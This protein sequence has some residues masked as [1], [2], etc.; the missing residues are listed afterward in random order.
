MDE[1]LP[2]S[3]WSRCQ[4]IDRRLRYE[5]LAIDMDA[6]PMLV[7]GHQSG[8]EY[9]GYFH[10]SGYH[11]LIIGSAQ[12]GDFSGAVLRPGN[13]HAH[14]D[15]SDD[16][17]GLLSQRRLAP[18]HRIRCFAGWVKRL[19]RLRT[20]PKEEWHDTPRVFLQDLATVS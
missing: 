2:R 11:P 18:E 5:E 1:A 12:T 17:V 14:D 3:A 13:V 16:L 6:L 19:L 4:L 20:R 7:H 15:F 10:A 9:N 8:V